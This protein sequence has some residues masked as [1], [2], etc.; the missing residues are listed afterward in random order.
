V[1]CQASA[2]CS[3]S[4][5]IFTSLSNWRF[6]SSLTLDLY[7]SFPFLA[8]STSSPCVHTSTLILDLLHPT[9]TTTT[10]SS[11]FPSLS[12]S[13]SLSLTTPRKEVS[14]TT[15]RIILPYLAAL[16]RRGASFPGEGSDIHISPLFSSTQPN[17]H[18]LPA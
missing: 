7:L 10:S 2:C 4:S 15:R 12:L 18:Y 11:C 13:L 17:I 3:I 5:A 8:P 6:F 16:Y 9:T 14:T 1:G